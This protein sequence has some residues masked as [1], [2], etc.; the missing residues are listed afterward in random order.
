MKMIDQKATLLNLKSQTKMTISLQQV[1]KMQKDFYPK[2]KNYEHISRSPDARSSSHYSI[3]NSNLNDEIF[4]NDDSKRST[5]RASITNS[6]KQDLSKP[7]QK[8]LMSNIN[9]YIEILAKSLG[10]K[11]KIRLKIKKI[12]YEHLKCWRRL[13]RQEPKFI[14]RRSRKVVSGIGC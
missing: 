14:M 3:G 2:T 4:I 10:K 1:H 6:L 9:F 13:M 5:K 7:T 11:K 12:Y 8:S